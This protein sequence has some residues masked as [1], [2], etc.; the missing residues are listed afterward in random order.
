MGAGDKKRSSLGG[1]SIL[2]SRARYYDPQAGRFLSRDPIGFKGG[3][4]Q[5]SYTLNNPVNWRD[6]LGLD[7]YNLCQGFS[8]IPYWLCKKYVDWGC[9]GEKNIACCEAEQKEC[10]LKIDPCSPTADKEAK[11]CYDEY[12]KCMSNTKK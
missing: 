10:I 4:N 9:R 3:I 2:I 7:L 8:G 12:Q 5:Y 1:R 11:D 6:P